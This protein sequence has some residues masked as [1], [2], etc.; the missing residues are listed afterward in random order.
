MQQQGVIF[1]VIM[2]P[3]QIKGTEESYETEGYIVVLN[4]VWKREA[5]KSC[6]Q[7]Q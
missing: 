7:N 1:H 6:R 5:R 2:G 4:Y 3:P